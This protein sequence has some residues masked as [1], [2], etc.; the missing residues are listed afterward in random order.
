MLRSRGVRCL[1]ISPGVVDT[2]FHDNTPPEVLQ[3][4]AGQT[5]M[6]RMAQPEEIAETVLFAC[7]D[8]AN[9]LT[10]DTI[11]VTGGLR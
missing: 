5:P 8:G 6:G 4:Y 7:S 11:F 1:S 3:G 2:P 10:A 9:Y